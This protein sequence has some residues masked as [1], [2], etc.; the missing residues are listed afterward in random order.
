MFR[1]AWLLTQMEEYEAGEKLYLD[2]I[3]YRQQ[4]MPNDLL[5]LAFARVGLGALY[6]DLGDFQAAL[7][8]C[9]QALIDLRKAAGNSPLTEAMGQFQQAM[10]QRELLGNVA[11]AEVQL[12][13]CVETVRRELGPLHPFTGLALHERAMT[14]WNRKRFTE[15]ERDFV[16]CM[17]IARHIGLQHPKIDILLSNYGLFLHERGRPLEVDALF[18]EARDSRIELLG[19][20]HHLVADL[21]MNHGLL[22]AE[23]NDR[24]GQEAKLREALDLYRQASGRPRRAMVDCLYN[25]ALCLGEERAEEAEQL[26][27]EAADTRRGLGKGKGVNLAAMLTALASARMDQEKFDDVEGPLREALELQAAVPNAD[28]DALRW[29]WMEMSRWQRAVGSSTAALESLIEARKLARGKSRALFEVACGMSECITDKASDADRLHA[30]NAALTTLNEA[31]SAGFRNRS[32][33]QTHASLAP[34]RSDPAFHAVIDRLPKPAPMTQ[35][36]S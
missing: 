8:P 24:T 3:Q 18:D 36:P 17:K 29:T 35:R 23:R 21:L 12:T 30:R 22:L 2:L 9:G 19:A 1:L 32:A 16:E 28:R 26:L 11:E 33:L 6:L 31:V 20:S 4:H 25:L 13:R 5:G 27:L 15:A 34:L 10:I 7:R 14:L